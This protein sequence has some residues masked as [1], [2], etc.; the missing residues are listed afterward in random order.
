MTD[1]VKKPFFS[2]FLSQLTFFLEGGG[3]NV[4]KTKKNMLPALRRREHVFFVIP[5]QREALWTP[6]FGEVTRI[7]LP[8]DT[9]GFI[10]HEEAVDV[11][12]Q[13]TALK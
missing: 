13:E 3:N 2:T 4:K 11:L 1:I 7:F 12:L 6:S 9:G 10:T 8:V 5:R